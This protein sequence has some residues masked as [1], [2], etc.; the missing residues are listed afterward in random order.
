[1]RI[2]GLV[3]GL[4]LGVTGSAGAM[5]ADLSV[6]PRSAFGLHYSARGDRVEPFVVYDYEPGIVVRAYWLPPWR[7][8]HYFPTGGTVRLGRVEHL[9][10]ARH[11]EPAETFYRSWS[12]SVFLPERPREPAH[13]PELPPK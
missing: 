10:A 1:M 12:T 4:V 9:S 7:H 5:A 13:I 2:C 11:L 3:A 8:R 6:H